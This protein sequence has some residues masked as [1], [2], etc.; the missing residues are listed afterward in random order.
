MRILISGSSGFVGT[1]LVR[2][3]EDQGHEVVRLVR[4][5]IKPSKNT[6]CVDFSDPPQDLAHFEGFYA[7]IHLSGENIAKRWTKARKQKIVESRIKTTR[8]LADLICR[9]KMPPK[10]FLSASAI[11]FYGEKGDEV[12]IET[13]EKGQGFLPDLC[14]AW[15]ESASF[16][17]EKGVGVVHMRF[18]MILGKGGALSYM[19]PAFRFG[20]GGKMGTGEQ[21]VSWIHIKDLLQAVLFILQT[22]CIEGPVNFCAPGSV[23]QKEFAHLLAKTLHRPCIFT[24]PAFM[25]NLVFGEMAK[26]MLLCSTR[27]YPNVLWQNGFSFLFPNLEGALQEIVQ[28]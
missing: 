22:P 10:L 8:Y 12:V 5:A 4:N 14:E 7:F 2:F 23:R 17:R 11:G 16:A 26:D 24:M 9:L 1:A 21:Y 28:S 13:K 20:L 27:A 6:L 18:G 15:E 25:L 3:L 19:L